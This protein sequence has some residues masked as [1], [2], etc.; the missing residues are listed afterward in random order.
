MSPRVPETVESFRA[1]DGVTLR[2]TRRRVGS[3]HA[4]LVVP[5]ILMHRDCPEHRLLAER[6]T[7]VADVLTLDVRGHGD[8]GGAFTWGEREPGDVATVAATLRREYQRVGGL[9]FS[10]GGYHAVLAAAR[11][12]PFDA[13]ALVAAP[14][15]L[16]LLDH[17]FLTCGLL[18]SLP[19]ML[20][21][22]RR[23]T[24]LGRFRFA[25]RPAPEGL[26]DRI[27]PTPLLIAHGSD[28]W[29]IPP[30]HA[31]VLY[32]KAGEPKRLALIEG[33]LH[34]ETMLADDPEPLLAPLI[35]FF[36]Q[37]LARP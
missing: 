29:L 31:R 25:R 4:V 18:R 6:L 13:V 10:Y 7:T 27:A 32:A 3:R 28:D 26:V 1:A 12:R 33:G 24:R 17:N 19:V 5:G 11:E 30:K 2:A 34:A 16:F 35:A 20:R 15:S 22:R 36:E 23:R 9:G 14:R 8:S 21:R 37:T